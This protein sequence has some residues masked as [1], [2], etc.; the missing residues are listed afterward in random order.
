[1]WRWRPGKGQEGTLGCPRALRVAN[2]VSTPP[3]PAS[4]ILQFFYKAA[5]LFLQHEAAVTVK[6]PHSLIHSFPSLS[7]PSWT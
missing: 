7:Q 4:L 5:L 6:R 2:F 3:L 1:M